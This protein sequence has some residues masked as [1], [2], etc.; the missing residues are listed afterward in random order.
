METIAQW[1]MND[2]G[3]ISFWS[4]TVWIALTFVLFLI[5]GL[6]SDKGIWGLLSGG[7]FLVVLIINGYIVATSDIFL[8]EKYATSAQKQ[9]LSFCIEDYK[10][11]NPDFQ[12]DS[13][14]MIDNAVSFC[15]KKKRIEEDR[16]KIESWK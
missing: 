13:I 3:V 16:R 14:F 12:E 11:Q 10:K 7:L 4:G 2:Y 6:C 8:G 15:K 5:V 9:K 1:L